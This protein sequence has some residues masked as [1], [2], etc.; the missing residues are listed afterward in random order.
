MGL[1]DTKAKFSSETDFRIYELEKRVK[2]LEEQ[3]GG[4]T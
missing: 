2:K 1:T 3:T 4:S